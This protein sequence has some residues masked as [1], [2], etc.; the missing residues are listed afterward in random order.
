MRV[1][2]FSTKSYDR[3]FLEDACA[4]F[5]HEL[6]FL[7]ARL[8]PATVEL[9]RGFDAVCA[10]V[11][12]QLDSGVLESLASH[13]IKVVALRCAGF[14]NVDLVR[15]EELGIIVVRVPAYSPHA[16]AEHAAGL[17]LTLNRKLHRAYARVRDGNFNLGGLLGFDLHGQTVGIVGTGQI[18]A[19]FAKIMKG[20]GC[21][22]IGYDL[23]PN[24]ECLDLGM[25]YVTL[26]RLFSDSDIISLHCP[27]TPETHYMVNAETIAQMK[28]GAMIINTSRGAVIDTQAV[29][30]GLK[31]G[32][33]GHLG[34]D[35]YEEEADVFFQDL[36]NEVIPDDTLSRLL[37]FPNVV[38]TG[39][40][41]FFTKDA[42]Q[43]IA[44][45]TLNNITAI[46][47]D[48]SCSNEVG[49]DVMKA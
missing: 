38:I 31:S 11:N 48:G 46:E 16:V 39:H 37:T 1:V 13:G 6:T 43:C 29:I 42:L 44:E 28:D 21:E 22:L 12:D 32:K 4:Q 5:P 2:V 10:F 20:F 30:D 23:K 17:V 36:S 41:A 26:P 25:E 34:L 18:G 49:S 27:V 33:I 35:V 9:A 24:Q 3:E 14:N 47:R 8:T 40:Q 45:T 15:A 19:V 7:E